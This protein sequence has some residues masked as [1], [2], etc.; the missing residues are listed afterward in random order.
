[1]KALLSA[2]FLLVAT[3]AAS[4]SLI[5]PQVK[6][7]QPVVATYHCPTGKPF[8]VTYWNGDNG[9]SFALM[10]IDGRPTLLVNT[11]SADGVRYAAGSAVWWTKGRDA[12]LYDSR[13]EPEK[14][15]LAGCSSH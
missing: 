1:M 5:I 8:T 10:R 12:D 14:P 7:G 13:V 6:F 11:M 3:G 15:T 2:A 9:Q 4:D